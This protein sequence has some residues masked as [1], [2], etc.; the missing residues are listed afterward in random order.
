MARLAACRLFAWTIRRAKSAKSIR[1]YPTLFT[2]LRESSVLNKLPMENSNLSKNRSQS[3]FSGRSLQMNLIEEALCKERNKTVLSIQSHVVH[4]YAGNKASVF[5]LQLNGFEVDPI[6]SVQFSNHA[7]NVEFLNLPKRYEYVR[8]QRLT[9]VEL[10]DLYDGLKLNNINEYSYVL[11]GYCGNVAFLT[12]IADIIKDLKNNDPN[13]FYVCDPVMGDNGKY[14]VPKELLPVYRDIITPLAN[15]LTPNAFELGQLVGFQVVT[16][17]DCIRGMDIIHDLGVTNVVVTSGVEESEGID[18]LTC[19]ASTRDTTG[20]V[21]RF[22]FRFPRLQGQFVGTGD[23][24]TSLLIVW[25]S[26]CENDV[27]EAVGHVLGSMQGLIR[28]TSKY[29]QA[30][31]DSNSRKTCELRLVESRMDLLVPESVIRGE[32]I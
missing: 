29:A 9:D 8:G 11:T 3:R 26:N 16:E 19:Y 18:T 6:N 22:R 5:P 7:G 32:P 14:Y 24:F 20:D 30:Q 10:N 28:R 12:K 21:R 31:V 27:C 1:M 2:C 13:V 4:G 23:V 15:V 25:L 17:E